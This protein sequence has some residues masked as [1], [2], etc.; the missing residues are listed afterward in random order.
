MGL[1]VDTAAHR[2]SLNAAEGSRPV[3]RTFGRPLIGL[4][5][6]FAVAINALAAATLGVEV[7]LADDGPGQTF[8]LCAHDSQG[9]PVSPVPKDRTCILH[10]LLCLPDLKLALA[11][12][13]AAAMQTAGFQAAPIAWP[14]D[15]WRLA[16]V[17]RDATTRPRGPPYSA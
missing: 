7:A 16:P 6:A 4:V 2:M 17:S 9:L 8:A 12:P 15:V 5:I 10:C 13:E 11:A 3:W 14:A 1:P